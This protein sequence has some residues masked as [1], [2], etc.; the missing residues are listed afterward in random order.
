[1]L[2]T[3][4]PPVVV[5]IGQVAQGDWSRDSAKMREI[6]TSEAIPNSL[7]NLIAMQDTW[8]LCLRYVFAVAIVACCFSCSC[9]C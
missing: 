4:K 8:D 2:C 9:K 1:M 5:A 6:T 3:V 7:C